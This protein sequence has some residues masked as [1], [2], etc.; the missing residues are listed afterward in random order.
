MKI[1]LAILLL[2]SLNIHAQNICVSVDC[3]DSV[4]YPNPITLNGSTTSTDGVKS[5]L[6]T[7]T[8]GTAT[9][10]NPNVDTAIATAQSDGLYVFLLTGTSQKGAVGT[11]FDSVIYVAN[12]PPTAT[13]GPSYTDTTTAGVLKGSGTDPEGGA[14][15]Y[16]WNQINGPNQAVITSTTFQ[17]PLITGLITGTYI[18]QLTVIDDGGLKGT[19]T[20][21]IYA[22]LPITQIKTVI[23]TTKYFSDGT[24]HTSTVTTVP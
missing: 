15:T 21:T 2:V 19:A 16:Q 7:I 8:K 18:F 13:C 23:V 9:L 22:T 20:Q 4:K 12:K 6:W 14:I 5:R 1:I 3:K 24:T 10:N 11:A 17:N